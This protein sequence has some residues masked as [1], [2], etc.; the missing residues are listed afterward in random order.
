MNSWKDVIVGNLEDA[1]E[2]ILS[3]KIFSSDNI[4]FVKEMLDKHDSYLASVEP[5]AFLDDV[6]TKNVLIQDGRLIGIIDLDWLC[7]GDSLYFIALTNMALLN[8]DRDTKYIEYLLEEV[9][10]TDYEREIV[11]LYTLVFCFIFM[12]EKGMAFN[13]DTAPA[14]DPVEISR[15]NRIFD[16]LYKEL[17]TKTV[18]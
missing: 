1:Q 3:T 11:K 8:S 12:S 16:Q 14:V 17:N 18:L 6:T 4:L 9:K 5:I 2:A 15:L 7:F 10:A 13:K